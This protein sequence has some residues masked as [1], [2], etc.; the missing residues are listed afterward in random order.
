MQTVSP[1]IFGFFFFLFEDVPVVWEGAKGHEQYWT[2]DAQ[3]G[4][5]GGKPSV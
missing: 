1:Q 4:L 3:A 2:S 5:P